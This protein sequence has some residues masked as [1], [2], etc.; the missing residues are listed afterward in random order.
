MQGYN[1]AMK[2]Y[3]GRPGKSLRTLCVSVSLRWPF[4]FLS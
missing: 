3:P 1:P 2:V 4:F